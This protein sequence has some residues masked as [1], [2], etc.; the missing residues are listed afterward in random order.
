MS[1]AIDALRHLRR[2]LLFILLAMMLGPASVS[3]LRT[4]AHK[5]CPV[6]IDRYGGFAPSE[7][8]LDLP[9]PNVRPGR[10]WPSS[11]AAGGFGLFAFYFVWWR[12]RPR[13]A[14]A[15]LIVALTYGFVLGLGR[16]MQGALFL[17]YALWSAVIVW[18]VV[19]L[20]YW[21]VL[22]WADDKGQASWG[23]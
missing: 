1:F 2:P 19:L 3:V 4:V 13:R 15:A 9:A 6:D 11:H 10:C 22:G 23:A 5:H 8:L 16:V 21:A 18:F 12:R 20:V 7:R 17:S 14:I